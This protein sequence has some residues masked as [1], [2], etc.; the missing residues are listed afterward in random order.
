MAS[1]KDLACDLCLSL[2]GR[3][4]TTKVRIYNII[5]D[6]GYGKLSADRALHQFIE[7]YHELGRTL[8][9][10][11]ELADKIN[12]LVVTEKSDE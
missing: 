1:D 6:V 8:D 4:A 11:H 3:I 7:D 10:M 9:A 5:R 2:A 12:E